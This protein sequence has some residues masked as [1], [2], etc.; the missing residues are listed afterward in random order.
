MVYCDEVFLGIALR[1]VVSREREVKQFV[2]NGAV[3]EGKIFIV[4]D[5]ADSYDSRYFGFVNTDQ[6]FGRVIFGVKLL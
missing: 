3:P 5:S 2:F 4:G 1:G 6:V